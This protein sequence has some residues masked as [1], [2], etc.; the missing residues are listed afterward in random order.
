MV[1]CVGLASA[2][3]VVTYHNDAARTGQ[4]LNER[5]LTTSNVN[6][7]NFG[8]LFTMPVDG[9]IDAEPLYLSGVVMA[10]GL[11][12]VL[13]VVTE[14]DSVYAFDADVGGQLW[15]VSLLKT[16]E[17]PSD[18]FGCTQISPQIGITS[19]PVIDRSSGPH[20]TMY[21]VAMSKNSSTYF[22]RIHALDVTTG[23]EEFGGPVSVQAKYPGTGDNSRNGFVI[24][25]PKQYA[26]RQ[27]LLLL[28]HVVYTGWTSHCDFRPYTGWLIGY[29]ESTLMQTSILN[30]TP[31][32]HEGSIW[33]SGA[34]IASDGSNIYLL[35]ANGTFDTSL[36]AQGFPKNGDFGNAFV[37]VSTLNN[38]LAVMDY[39]EMYNGV[40]ESQADLDF[41]SGGALVLPPMK[42]SNGS[43]RYLSIGAGKDGNIYIVDRTNMGKFHP[44]K[45]A[46][47]QEIDRA[48]AGGMWAMPAFFRGNLY[49]G[50]Q[51]T[52]LLHFHFSQAKLS[53][54]PVS[55]SASSFPY[56]GT[57]PSISANGTTNGIVW[58][59]E[60]R[61]PNDVLHAYD[62]TNLAIE[63]Y[64]SNRPR[65]AF[66]QASHFGTPMIVNGKVY[67]GTV[68]NVTVFGLL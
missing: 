23:Q 56:P 1:C 26:E 11:H 66:G 36:N 42:D 32:G 61:N 18:D 55:R 34:G 45:N 19:T 25:D 37:K 30:L 12:N 58:A 5:I 68:T 4:N 52:K 16:G 6:S 50:P 24:F 13:Y 54:Q 57:T 8:K 43:T 53:P 17:T 31:H 39:F 44:Q 48:L 21:V 28:N 10:S 51:G 62:A 67:V 20:G 65:D 7:S 22:Q 64:N 63:L 47:Y 33:Q 29:N 40:S 2:T 41:G 38:K 35:D 15:Q 60:H 46:I 9:V 14:N 3:D 59:I 49:F 27:G